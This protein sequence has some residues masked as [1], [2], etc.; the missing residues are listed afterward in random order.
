MADKKQSKPAQ[1]P[2]APQR[3]KETVTVR[4]NY[5]DLS[6]GTYR[7]PAIKAEPKKSD[8]SSTGPRNKK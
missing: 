8:T 3:P 1:A 6:A 7:A 4:I 2:Q 5:S